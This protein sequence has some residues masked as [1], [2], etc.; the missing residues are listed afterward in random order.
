M[1]YITTF[2]KP[3]K[4]YTRTFKGIAR[5]YWPYAAWISGDGKTGRYAVLAACGRGLTVTLH[6]SLHDAEVSKTQIDVMGCGGNCF[7][8]NGHRIVDLATATKNEAL[9][10]DS[11]LPLRTE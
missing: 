1:N 11:F 3:R 2:V 5:S 8:G 7:H 10:A 9:Q 4:P 6:E